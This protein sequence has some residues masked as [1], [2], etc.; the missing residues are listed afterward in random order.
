MILIHLLQAPHG[1]RLVEQGHLAAHLV[2]NHVA[3]QNVG[4][5]GEF[6]KVATHLVKAAVAMFLPQTVQRFEPR[7]AAVVEGINTFAGTFGHGERLLQTDGLNRCHD[8]IQARI[9][10]L[11]RVERK[12]LN[13]IDG[14]GNFLGAANQRAVFRRRQF[15][16]HLRSQ[17]VVV[18][19][20]GHRSLL[21]P[22]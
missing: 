9:V 15:P 20:S 17:N 12:F 2:F 18:G 21:L 4:I 8:F 5:R 10:R 11:T 16:V 22:P 19:I 14:D 7:I 13:V 1:Q 6:N 3:Q